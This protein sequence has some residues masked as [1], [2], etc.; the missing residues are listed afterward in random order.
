[1]SLFSLGG[2]YPRERGAGDGVGTGKVI[3]EGI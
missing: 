3:R 2:R 1:M